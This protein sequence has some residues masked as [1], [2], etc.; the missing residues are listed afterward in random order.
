MQAN[1]IPGNVMLFSE[2]VRNAD[3]KAKEL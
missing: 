3:S 2:A 1:N